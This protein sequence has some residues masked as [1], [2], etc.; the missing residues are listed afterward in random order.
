MKENQ[1]F[2]KTANYQ[3]SSGSDKIFNHSDIELLLG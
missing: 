3:R 2:K 1:R